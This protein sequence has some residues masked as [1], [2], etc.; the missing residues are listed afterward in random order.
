MI[1]I[2]VMLAERGGL[3][4]YVVRMISG[5]LAEQIEQA[6]RPIR[7]IRPIRLTHVPMAALL[8]RVVCHLGSGQTRSA[9][10]RGTPQRVNFVK[11]AE[12]VYRPKRTQHATTELR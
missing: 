11:A 7:P 8:S 2:V 9:R 4:A 12:S 1:S 3:I 6:L 5:W 10:R